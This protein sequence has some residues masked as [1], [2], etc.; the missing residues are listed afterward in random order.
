ME[1]RIA[2][3]LDVIKPSATLAIAQRAAE[4]KAK[5]IDVLSFSVGEPDFE[6]PPH[7]SEAARAAVAKGASKYSTVRGLAALRQ[8]ICD[9]SKARRG[10]VVHAPEDVVVSI[11][12]KHTLFNLAMALFEPGDEIVIP[13]PY[14]VSYPEQALLAGA[15]PVFVPS[16]REQGYRIRARDLASAITSRTRALVLCSPS[17]PTGAAYRAGELA[18]LAEVVRSHDFYVIVDEIYGELVY[19]GFEQRSLLELAPDLRERLIIVDGV[20]KTYAMTGWRI[21]WMLGPRDVARACDTIQGQSTTNPALATQEAALAAL[22]GPTDVVEQMRQEFE[23][24]REIIVSG[25]NTIRGLSCEKPEG[26]FYAWV[27]ATGILGKRSDSGVLE[28]DVDVAQ[29]LLDSARC[30]LVPG[31]PFGGPGHLRMSYAASRDQIR[32]GLSRI[33]AAVEKLG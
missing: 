30:A 10:G 24:R 15:T 3:R 22:L 18:E 13:A 17:N 9:R 33:K 28:T 23:A 27:D 1:R 12:A 29:F 6:P 21:G 14:W 11:G 26:A 8:A 31:T 16:T 4:L 32:E 2:K 19:E 5:G 20:S 7:V 25:I